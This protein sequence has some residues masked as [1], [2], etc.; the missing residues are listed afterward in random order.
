MI[1]SVFK[2]LCPN[3]GSDITYQ[4]LQ[5]GLL[6][7]N[8][9][10][11]ENVNPCDYIEFG[12]FKHY[13]DIQKEKEKW[14]KHFEEHIHSKPWSLQTA[15]AKRVFSGSSF[16]LL[17]PTGVGKTSFG[18]CT[19]T[20]FAEKGKKSYIILPTKLLVEQVSFRLK[21]F[22]S[23]DYVLT[24]NEEGAKT[25]KINKER[26]VRGDFRILVTTSMFLYKNFQ[27]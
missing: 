2:N 10:P 7:E 27:I 22:V 1:C 4:R 9:L 16:A 15:W 3:C 5:N 6:C 25:K 23:E 11:K 17:A 14:E 20:Y 24:F 12:N 18:V 19:A 8:C 26:L 13:C 21:N